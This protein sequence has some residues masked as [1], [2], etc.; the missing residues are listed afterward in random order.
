MQFHTTRGRP[1]FP[2]L[3]YQ[4]SFRIWCVHMFI[5]EASPRD[6]VVVDIKGSCSSPMG[7]CIF[8]PSNLLELSLPSLARVTLPGRFNLF[9]IRP[10]CTSHLSPLP[11]FSSRVWPSLLLFLHLSAQVKKL[12]LLGGSH[13]LKSF[14]SIRDTNYLPSVRHCGA[15]FTTRE[16]CY[17]HCPKLQYCTFT[18]AREELETP[19]TC[20][21]N[22]HDEL[23][24]EECTTTEVQCGHGA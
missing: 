13:H 14:C 2:D 20:A 6:P 18:A 1:T 8:V 10:T 12:D 15:H 16:N 4:S 9:K 21:C 7:G 11:P 17:N 5:A 22:H 3:S 19:W 23:Q 24:T